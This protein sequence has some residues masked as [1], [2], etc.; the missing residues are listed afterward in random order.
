M[1]RRGDCNQ[2]LSIHVRFPTMTKIPLL[3]VE[4]DEEIQ[5]QMKWALMADF[6]VYMA[7]DRRSANEQFCT[8]RPLVVLL[9]LGL[10]PR[11]ASPKKAWPR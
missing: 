11:P 7:N 2:I 6:D 8:V 5:S 1:L 4:D 9:D 3:I 10:P